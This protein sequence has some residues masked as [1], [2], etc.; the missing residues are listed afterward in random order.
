[1]TSCVSCGGQLKP[2]LDMPIDAKKN[3]TTPYGHVVRCVDC[4]IGSLDPVPPADVIP[5]LYALERYY[6]HG[7]GHM[8][9]RP[10][11]GFF[12]K[13]LTRLAYSF[14]KGHSFLPTEIAKR[15]PKGASIVDLGC[16]AG[17]YI[18]EFSQLGFDVLG[19][20]PDANAR[21]QLKVPVLDGTAENLPDV[22]GKRQ[23]DLVIMTHA[24]EH[25]RDARKAIENARKLTKAGGLCYIEVPNCDAEHFRRFTTCSEMF[26]APRHIHFFTMKALT[27]LAGT[28]GFSVVEKRHVYYQRNFAP[29]WRDWEMEIA[30]RAGFG[31]RH[32]LFQS[33]LLFFASFWR[34]RDRKYD[35]IGLL[36]RA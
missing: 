16:G 33:W 20:E 12:D 32:T 31:R 30:N 10:P 3:E 26:D 21:A 7:H 27:R 28:V 1:M 25:C 11:V 9:P 6:T 5:S 13:L 17:M 4:E 22:M 19:V 2:W 34:S 24:L 35:S 14:D 23:F 18:T 15:L 8:K 29:L 36:L